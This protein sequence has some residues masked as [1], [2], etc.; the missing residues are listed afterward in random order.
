MTRSQKL[1]KLKELVRTLFRDDNGRP[2][3]MTDGQAELFDAIY[4]RRKLRVQFECATQYGKSEVVSMAVLLRACTFP[5]RWIVLGGSADKARIIMKKL[6]KHVFENEYCLARFDVGKDESLERIKR[7]RSKDRLTFKVTD[8]GDMGEVMILSADSRRKGEDAGDILVGHGTQNLI[9]DDAA[10]IPDNISAKAMRMLGGHRDGFLLKITNSLRRNHAFR[11][12]ND[13]AYDVHVIDW[14]RAVAEGRY[15]EAYIDEM[16]KVMDPYLFGA[17]YDCVYPPSDA[18]DDEGWMPLLSDDAIQAAQSRAGIEPYG[19]VRMGCDIGEGRN[20][21]VAVT[22]TDNVA[23]L[24]DKRQEPDLM[25]T[26]NWLAEK[27]KDRTV[28][29]ERMFIDAIG[30]GAGVVSRL[31]EKRLDAVG[32]KSGEKATQKKPH[33]LE[34]DPVEFANLKAEMAWKAKRWVEQGGAL[35]PS[36]DWSQLSKIRYRESNLKRIEIMPKE[37]MR[38]NGLMGPS[39][40]P[41]VADALFLTFAPEQVKFNMAASAPLKPYFPELG[42]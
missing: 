4:S 35:S 17:F 32:V 9:M 14:R 12:R 8:K 42:V 2:F 15:T 22:R 34:A 30:I 37:R 39:E 1:Q 29:P 5:E 38:L 11:S 28:E 6:I 31:R 10:L 27:V 16:R 21:T 23:R 36:P 20:Y 7:E 3:E 40:S 24:I 19:P 26:A 13:P 25:A 33:E 41:D 18:A